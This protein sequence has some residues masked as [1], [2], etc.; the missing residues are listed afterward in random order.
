MFTINKNDNENNNNDTSSL[1]A[2]LYLV[3]LFSLLHPPSLF[4]SFFL[5]RH[6]F[7]NLFDFFLLPFPLWHSSTFFLP[8]LSSPP[9]F[10]VPFPLWPSFPRS[11]PLCY[12]CIGGITKRFVVRFIINLHFQCFRSI[13]LESLLP[14]LSFPSS[15]SVSPFFFLSL[16]LVFPPPLP[17]S[18][19]YALPFSSS[20]SSSFYSP[21]FSLPSHYFPSFCLLTFISLFSFTLFAY[22]PILDSY[23]LP[24]HFLP[25]L[26]YL[27]LS[28]PPLLFPSLSRRDT[29]A[30]N[31]QHKG[32]NKLIQK[33]SVGCNGAKKI[34]IYWLRVFY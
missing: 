22:L 2:H 28:L 7:V 5:Q 29:Q 16:F 13:F 23:F 12:E 6:S 33:L 25:C 34:K 21:L 17:L 4:L 9:L 31:A 10:P 15:P 27:S 32:N 26:P 8:S 3:S 11:M 30:R 20:H 18:H 19:T 24:L 14:F 1:L